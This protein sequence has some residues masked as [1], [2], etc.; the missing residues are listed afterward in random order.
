MN[1]NKE[2]RRKLIEASIPL[3]A[4]SRATEL[5]E[6]G[7]EIEQLAIEA[8]LTAEHQHGGAPTGMLGAE[9]RACEISWRLNLVKLLSASS[10]PE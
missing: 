5:S 3:Q 2:R 1:V 7:E 4:I 10:A 8:V 9:P 6:G